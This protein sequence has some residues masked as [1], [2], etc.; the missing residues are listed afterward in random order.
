LSI[1]NRVGHFLLC[2]PATLI[3]CQVAWN[4]RSLSWFLV[5]QSVRPDWKSLCW[6]APFPCSCF[7][8]SCPFYRIRSSTIKP[9]QTVFIPE[10]GNHYE[11]S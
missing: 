8:A 5:S 2:N 9:H 6:Q 7:T 4:G 3:L 1:V 11:N 10:R